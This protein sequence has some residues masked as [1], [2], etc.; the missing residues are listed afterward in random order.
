MGQLLHLLC[1]LSL[2]TLDRVFLVETKYIREPK[3][4]STRKGSTL[5]GTTRGVTPATEK[6]K[7]TPSRK[8]LMTVSTSQNTGLSSLHLRHLN[9][10]TKVSS[11]LVATK[12]VPPWVP[13][14]GTEGLRVHTRHLV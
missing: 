12:L 3:D 11:H 2:D 8:L 6:T 5:G 10:L 4:G 7:P 14:V 1:L 9:G 13:E